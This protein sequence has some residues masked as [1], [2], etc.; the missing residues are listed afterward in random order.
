MLQLGHDV[1]STVGGA[2][3]KRCALPPV[4]VDEP[5][6]AEEVEA[7]LLELGIVVHA[8]EVEPLHPST[9][10]RTPAALNIWNGLMHST[11]IP[12]HAFGIFTINREF[13]ATSCVTTVW[14]CA[15][16]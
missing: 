15:C 8:L 10:N 2:R 1:A 3:R 12:A 6:L 9:T 14:L 13:L 11:F 7:K 5:Q 16:A 4:N